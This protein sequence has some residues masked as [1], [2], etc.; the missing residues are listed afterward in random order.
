MKELLRAVSFLFAL[1]K[2]NRPKQKKTCV[3]HFWPPLL[4]DN[5]PGTIFLL[6]KKDETKHPLPFVI[7]VWFFYSSIR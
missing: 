5:K 3:H 7:L 6:M 2:E 1:W 4:H